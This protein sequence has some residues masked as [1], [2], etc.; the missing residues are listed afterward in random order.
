MS[1]FAHHQSKH[2]RLTIL[3]FLSDSPEYVSNAS[4]LTDVC[5]GLGIPSTRDQVLGDIAWLTE[6]AMVT[7]EDHGSF[8]VVTATTRGIEIATGRAFHDG[9]KRPRP[10]V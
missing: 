6:N 7:R 1:D 5:N 3:R 4:M 9:V 2:R 8:V 10:G